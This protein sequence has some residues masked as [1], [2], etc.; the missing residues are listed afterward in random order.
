MAITLL[1]PAAKP[2]PQT[3][4]TNADPGG[5]G[6]SAAGGDFASLLLG[7]L[8]AGTTPQALVAGTGNESAAD[9]APPGSDGVTL[10][11]SD[12]AEASAAQLMAALA[13]VPP[14]ETR[15]TPPSAPAPASGDALPGL[16]QGLSTP[17]TTTHDAGQPPLET[18]AAASKT[19]G[20]AIPLAAAGNDK[21][22][23]KFAETL[24][25]AS[26]RLPQLQAAA[27][28]SANT[29]ALPLHAQTTAQTSPLRHEAT[30]AV[31]TPVR[32]ANWNQD[33]GQKIVWLAGN[34]KQ[35]AELTLNPPQMGPIEI[36]LNIDKG[37]ATASFVSANADVRQSIESALPKL[38]E[39]LAGA[40]IELGQANVSAE[41]FRQA[42]SGANG[43]GQARGDG[44][45]RGE[46]AILGA[47]AASTVAPRSTLSVRGSSL[48]DIFA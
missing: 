17:A 13:L 10:S 37:S 20:E 12:S 3:A 45:W 47:D 40:G 35:S 1:T 11:A 9:Q 14:V 7:Q 2:A 8:A 48:V 23:A 43:E 44:Q 21:S 5:D 28:T 18:D 26:D 46:P 22:P 42:N 33:F 27:E 38:R 16:A 36:S 39:M 30:L 4:G 41:S 34:G 15:I 31:Q 19:D 25:H 6:A 24:A 29:P 32:D